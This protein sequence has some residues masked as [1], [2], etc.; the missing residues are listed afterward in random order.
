MTQNIL[1]GKNILG[2]DPLSISRNSNQIVKNFRILLAYIFVVL[3]FFMSVNWMVTNRLVCKNQLKQS[4]RDYFKILVV[5]FFYLGLIFLFFFSLFNI[6][7]TEA[8]AQ[9]TK[10]IGKYLL[11]LLVSIVLFYFMFISLSLLAK[12][13]IKNIVQKTLTIGVRKIHYMATVY[14][15][16][17]ILLVLSIFMFIYFIEINFFIVLMAMILFVFSFVFGRIFISNVVEKLD[18]N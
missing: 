16:N 14:L 2:D 10:I 13:D 4:S 5:L 3:I 15:I 9:G 12:V 1:Q 18:S 17:I 6:S 11:F 7:F 8:A